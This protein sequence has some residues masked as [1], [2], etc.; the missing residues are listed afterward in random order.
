VD[1]STF[2]EDA[3]VRRLTAMALEDFEERDWDGAEALLAQ[4][5][6]KRPG[7]GFAAHLRERIAPLRLAPP[8]PDWDAAESLEKL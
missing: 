5:E 8:G 3:D 6:Q 2:D 4:L 7:D 1:V